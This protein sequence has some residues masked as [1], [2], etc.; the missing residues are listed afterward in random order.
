MIDLFCLDEEFK[1]M[2]HYWENYKLA[3]SALNVLFGMCTKLMWTAS[4]MPVEPVMVP[5]P[6]Q[7]VENTRELRSGKDKA[8][9]VKAKAPV[10][11]NIPEIVQASR[12]MPELLGHMRFVGNPGSGAMFVR[13]EDHLN[14]LYIYIFF[15]AFRK[16]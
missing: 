10:A 3:K 6:N 13:V 14:Y 8:K 9:E 12:H 15:F 7:V 1:V 4:L 11:S 5:P 16:N 2:V